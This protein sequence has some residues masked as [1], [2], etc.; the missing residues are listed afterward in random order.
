MRQYLKMT[1]SCNIVATKHKNETVPVY[2][3]WY[4]TDCYPDGTLF[5]LTSLSDQVS[6]H[7]LVQSDLVRFPEIKCSTVPRDFS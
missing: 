6:L 7:K 3:L 5:S 2:E 1:V 4:K